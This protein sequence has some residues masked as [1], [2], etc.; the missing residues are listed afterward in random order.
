MEKPPVGMGIQGFHR[1]VIIFGSG[2]PE[3]QPLENQDV[4]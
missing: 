4:S 2:S 3:C 1:R